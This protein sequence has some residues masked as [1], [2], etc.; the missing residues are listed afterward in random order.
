M[1]LLCLRVDFLDAK[2]K[3]LSFANSGP[4]ERGYIHTESWALAT[5][6]HCCDQDFRVEAK[7]LEPSNLLTASQN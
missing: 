3:Q 7:G 6:T 2:S 4:A 1:H 5:P